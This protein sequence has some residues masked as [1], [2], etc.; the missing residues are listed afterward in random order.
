MLQLQF[1]MGGLGHCVRQHR[2]FLS[3][4]ITKAAAAGDHTFD[5]FLEDGAA[6]VSSH[7]GQR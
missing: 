5:V 3:Q 6:P 1:I 7:W 4:L 2:Q